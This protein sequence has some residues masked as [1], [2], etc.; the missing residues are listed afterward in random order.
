MITIGGDRVWN[1]LRV[2]ALVAFAGVIA[3]C[4]WGGD[5]ASLPLSSPNG[6]VIAEGSGIATASLGDAQQRIFIIPGETTGRSISIVPSEPGAL[7]DVTVAAGETMLATS[8][9]GG[10]HVIAIDS[11]SLSAGNT[12]PYKV[13]IR[14]RASGATAEITGEVQVLTPAIVATASIGEAGGA[15][16]TQS[17]DLRV[18]FDP[19][20]GALPLGVTVRVAEAP[21]GAKLIRVKF[22]RDVSTDTRLVRFVE[23]QSTALGRAVVLAAGHQPKAASFPTLVWNFGVAYYLDN[24]NYRIPG[25]ASLAALDKG[26]CFW[27]GDFP[28]EICVTA[29]RAW[30][31]SAPTE[32]GM[33]IALERNAVPVLF[34]HGFQP[35]AGDVD[36]HNNNGGPTYWGEFPQRLQEL[37]ARVVPFEFR[38]YTNAKF[39]D[40]ADEL[41]AAINLIHTRTGGKRVTIVA[42]SF[43]GIL[44]RTMLQGL[45]TLNVSD[46]VEQL[47]TLGTPHSGITDKPLTVIA[48]KPSTIGD[49]SLPGGQDSLAFKACGQ[50]SCHQMGEPVGDIADDV[51]FARLLGV[52][53]APGK[54][55][56]RLASTQVNA[57][58][59]NVHIAAGIGLALDKFPANYVYRDGDALISWA[60]QRILPSDGLNGTALLN[61]ADI[62]QSRAKE[63]LLSGEDGRRPKKSLALSEYSDSRKGHGHSVL[64]VAG[65]SPASI[66]VNVREAE[67][68]VDDCSS[69]R[70]CSHASFRLVREALVDG[71]CRSPVVTGQSP[72]PVL[73][74]GETASLAVSA[75]SA[76]PLGG[77]ALTYKW[78]RSPDRITGPSPIAGATA[79][80]YDLPSVSLAD[81]GWIYWVLVKGSDG[82]GT[83]SQEFELRVNAVPPPPAADCGGQ[84]VSW[85]QG[86][87]TCNAS[88]AGGKSGTSALLS[89]VTEPTTGTAT[90]SCSNG[91]LNVTSPTCSTAPPPPPTLVA[92]TPLA[93]TGTITSLTPVFNW[94]GG[95]GAAN[96]EINVRDL[97][98]NTIVLRQQGLSTGSTSF[99][100]PAGTLVNARQYRWDITT[101]PN[102]ACSSGFVT[103]GNLTFTTQVAASPTVT[104]VSVVPS[105]PTVGTQATFSV[106]GANLQPGY[107]FSLPGC[108]ATEV[109]SVSTSLRQFTC[110]PTLAGT[111]L[112]GT[113][114]TAAGTALYAFVQ[115]VGAGVVLPLQRRE[116]ATGKFHSCALTSAGGVKC[117]GSNSNST[118]SAG[119]LGDGTSLNRLVPVDVVG[120]SSGVVAVSAGAFHTCALT[121]AGGV[122]CWGQNFGALGDGTELH[123]LTPVDVVGLGSG[124][125]AISASGGHTCALTSTGGVKCWGV[126]GGL[127]LGDGTTQNRLTPVDVVGLTGGAV[128]I[129]AGN[130]HTC[131][132]TGARGV[133][134]WGG[135]AGRLGDGT[136]QNRLTPVDV[137]GLGSGVMAITAGGSQTC[138]VTN[139][140]GA[141]CW[142][143]N[144]SGALGDG[145]TVNR[146]TPVDVAGLTSGVVALSAGDNH[147]CAVTTSGGVKC[148]GSDLSGQ[149]G[150]GAFNVDRLTP[151]DVTGLSSGVTAVSAGGQHTC[152]R[153]SVGGVKCWGFNGLGGLGDGT[154]NSRAVPLHVVGFQPA[155]NNPFMGNYAGS[156][157]GGQSGTWAATISVDSTIS[158]TATG[159]F[160]GT[161]SVNSAGTATIALD[162]TGASQGFTITFSGA[163]ALQSNGTMTGSGTWT[164][165]SGL[166]GTW[167][168][169]RLN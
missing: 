157:A 166:T 88:Y 127:G 12:Y 152:A 120:L 41:A 10:R 164:S 79:A 80:T 96:Y 35:G 61:C 168:G 18:E 86:T 44:A 143:N 130:T 121:T 19:Q 54:L 107:V 128:A 63:V 74:V 39:E 68:R 71:I 118:L 75:V 124:V 56:A 34:V 64:S 59:S 78:L 146:R 83:L 100:M 140:G 81:D 95:S 49:V 22:D 70:S 17:G 150:D 48:D 87:L 98:T 6:V 109:A 106:N 151:V 139:A 145:T 36:I 93:P 99:T 148:W 92:P 129:T 13:V 82:S 144:V 113:V 125:A 27:K 115:T 43:G 94:S 110:T 103:S 89:D 25:K 159:G 116:I 165:S 20:P 66:F 53:V 69:A 31:L 161:G 147:T 90:A 65:A 2:I 4:G 50:I 9:R 138:A 122:K 102:F 156:Y 24:G 7:F 135:N 131:A 77:G 30:E 163:F 57:P 62:G 114:S 60:G 1:A 97:T 8:E 23:P 123:R 91:V 28:R 11:N 3:G 153:T 137:L 58:A 40:V 169:A 5:S 14:N 33:R 167:A 38:W 105:T 46:K 101:C 85:T 133:K 108:A 47:I 136:D 21:S 42:H 162:G 26:S 154:T 142:G 160:V 117:W 134:C 84:A 112:S 32:E 52:D 67:L 119:Q 37:N 76:G 72:Q 29:R 16:V 111:N 45:G 155:G 141:K 126:M 73:R 15:I 158:A 104:S 149:L 51:D 132:L 55:E